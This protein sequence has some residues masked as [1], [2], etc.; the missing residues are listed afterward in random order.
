ML[1]K[2]T[3]SS[4]ITIAALLFLVVFL[5]DLKFKQWQKQRQ[6]EAE[7]QSLQRQADALQ[8]KNDDLSQ[9]LQYLNSPSFKER[10]AR[11]Q[12]DLKKAGE[13]V[14]SFSDSPQ[15]AG[16]F[17]EPAS[18]TGNIKKWWDYFFANN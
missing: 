3:L 7:K 12:L 16:A 9:S 10:V 2:Q 4:K 5:A 15:V 8:K 6:I 11:E 1:S 17:S 14:Y 18:G 13:Q